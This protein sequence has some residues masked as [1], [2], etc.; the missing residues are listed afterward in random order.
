MTGTRREQPRVYTAPW[1]QAFE[2]V[3]TPLEAFIQRQTT[4]SVLLMICAVLALILAN[5]PVGGNYLRA[6]HT[7]LALSVGTY[8]FSMSVQHWVNDG[9]MTLFFLLVGLELK[10]ELLVGE[11]AD[12]RRAA[13]PIV[14]ALGGMVVPALLFWC[15]NPSGAAAA[16]WGIP[17]ATDIAFAV[18]ALSLLGARVPASLVTLLVALAIVDDLGAVLVIALFYTQQL[19]MEALLAVLLLMVMLL[20]LNLG[21]IRSALPY[22]VTGFLLWCA[23]LSSGVHATL[24]G[25]ALAFAIPIQPK[26][27]PQHF[28][29]QAQAL[30]QKMT[31]SLQ[32]NSDIIHNDTLRAQV[33]ALEQG[34]ERVQA[35][36]QRLEHN[37]HFMVAYLV[38]PLFALTNAAIPME[39][40]RLADTLLHP[41]T[42][43][44]I[45]GLLLGKVLGIVGAAWLAV[46][47]QWAA[48]PTGLGFRHLIGVGLLGGI[49]FTMSIFVAEL[50]FANEAELLLMA[51][52]GI[53]FAS[54]L[55]GISGYCWLRF[56]SRQ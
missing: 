33:S 26:Y 53:L 30:L 8:H 11:L 1:E 43:G 2:R 5:S 29:A 12:T 49:G 23:M 47:W 28:I 10:R 35:P 52:T 24:A 25:V 4:S 22:M 27:N 31:S 40:S 3:L 56:T 21:G 18:G 14:A 9:L 45:S 36:A 13:L 46:R 32:H 6:L 15:W 54:L 41:V 38:I 19:N 44:V 48:L 17:M 39:F 37:L 42:A 16:G 51:K 7:P 20:A 50:G 55:A 34:T